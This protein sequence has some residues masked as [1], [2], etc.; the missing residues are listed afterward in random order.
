MTNTSLIIVCS[1][2]PV[3]DKVTRLLLQI[4]KNGTMHHYANLK[5]DN[6][7]FISKLTI[8]DVTIEKLP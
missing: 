1:K 4:E 6:T 7:H 3:L 2:N 5:V 8:S